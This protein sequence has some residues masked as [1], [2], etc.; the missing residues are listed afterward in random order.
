MQTADFTFV[1][2]AAHAAAMASLKSLDV[3]DRI[4]LLA[5]DRKARLDAFLRFTE[6]R[7]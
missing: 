1:P 7:R 4:L 2:T 6:E 5:R 3:A